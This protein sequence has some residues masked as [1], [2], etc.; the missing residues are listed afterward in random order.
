M[1]L[2][3]LLRFLIGLGMKLRDFWG[4]LHERNRSITSLGQQTNLWDDQWFTTS[5]SVTFGQKVIALKF[6]IWGVGDETK[7]E[8]ANKSAIINDT[9]MRSDAASLIQKIWKWN[10]NYREAESSKFMGTEKQIPEETLIWG[11]M[12]QRREK[13]WSQRLQY[14]IDEF[15]R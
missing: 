7:T 9:I 15:T 4:S 11:K 14:R 10:D 1:S 8:L 6:F 3:R 2:G 5:I 12:L 13:I